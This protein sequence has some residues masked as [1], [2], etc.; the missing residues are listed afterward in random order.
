MTIKDLNV[1]DRF[2]FLDD[3]NKETL[4]EECPVYQVVSKVI[5][6]YISEVTLID[7]DDFHIFRV[8]AD[9][10]MDAYLWCS[11]VVRLSMS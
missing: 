2:V 6:E 1:K 11:P 3:A 10:F 7:T 5:D 9:V 8:N 4:Q